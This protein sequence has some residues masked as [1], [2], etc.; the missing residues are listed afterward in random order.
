MDRRLIIDFVVND[1]QFSSIVDLP[2]FIRSFIQ[3]IILLVSKTISHHN[4]RLYKYYHFTNFSISVLDYCIV[5]VLSRQI[6]LLLLLFG[7][8]LCSSHGQC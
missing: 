6:C 5:L 7:S 1:V 3:A 4:F 2:S 8:L